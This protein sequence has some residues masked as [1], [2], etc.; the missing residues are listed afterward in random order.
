VFSL[1]VENIK[2]KI[3]MQNLLIYLFFVLW[4][5]VSMLI[6]TPV[7][8]IL[9]VGISCIILFIGS[10]VFGIIAGLLIPRRLVRDKNKRAMFA[11]ILM[12]LFTLLSIFFLARFIDQ[13][14]LSSFWM[15]AIFWSI[16]TINKLM[17]NPVD[18]N[19][20]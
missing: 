11:A 9:F 1:K 2:R 5:I 6:S 7:K 20:L 3:G 17:S 12:T 4:L 19:K 13:R 18:F 8:G 10:L 14:L 15:V 16:M